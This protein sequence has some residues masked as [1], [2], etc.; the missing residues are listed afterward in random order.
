M[1]KP[2]ELTTKEIDREHT[3]AN[4][5]M[6]IRSMLPEHV[7]YHIDIQTTANGEMLAKIVEN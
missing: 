3:R 5:L 2:N 7:A 4:T 6:K 1:M